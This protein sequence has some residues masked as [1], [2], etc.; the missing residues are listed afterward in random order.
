MVIKFGVVVG[1]RFTSGCRVL[2]PMPRSA[3]QCAK[4]SENSMAVAL[5]TRAARRLPAISI[6]T[7][8]KRK[9]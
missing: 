4:E 6:D 1:H 2:F 8:Q 7:N 9:F 5:Y 3:R